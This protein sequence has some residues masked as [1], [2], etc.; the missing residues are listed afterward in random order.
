MTGAEV[1][2]VVMARIGTGS[3]VT[4]I[5]TELR[6][7][8]Y[9]VSSRADFLTSVSG[10]VTVSGQAEYDE[11]A[12][13]KRVYECYIDMHGPLE[14]KTYRDYLKYIA[15]PT[16]ENAEPTMFA[17]RHGKLY[18]WPV[19]DGVYTVNVDYASYHPESFEDILFG[20]EFNEAIFEGVVTALYQG[21]LFEKLRL[22]EK[23]ITSRDVVESTTRD[24][25]SDTQTDMEGTADD[26]TVVVDD[27]FSG[28]VDKDDD[29][30]VL[31]YRF[32]KD[33]P[34]IK[35]HAEAYEAEIAKLIANIDIDTETVL[36]EYRD[37]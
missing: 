15:N 37:I 29:T 19:P 8:L 23:R 22:A 16:A 28:T 10:V 14:V 13:L 33:F 17:R 27:Q 20:P 25:D 1:L 4:S 2:G 12:G 34:E 35:K 11:P 18:L 7:V 6:G 36:V 26:K 30:D 31:V 5:H 3:G 24:T 32:S 9:D 21:Q